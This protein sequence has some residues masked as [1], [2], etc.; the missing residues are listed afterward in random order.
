MASGGASHTTILPLGAIIQEFRVLVSDEADARSVSV[1]NRD[2]HESSKVIAGPESPSPGKQKREQNLVLNFP[3]ADLYQQYNVPYFGETIGRV[4]NRISGAKLN[5][6]NGREYELPENDKPRK[7]C[8]HG[9]TRGWGKKTW[10]GP[11]LV[12]RE[13]WDV[14]EYQLVSEDG[15]EGFPGTVRAKI[16]YSQK[17]EDGA[18]GE[19]VSVLD[20]EYE[21]ELVGDEVAETVVAL[22]NHR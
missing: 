15:D 22:T 1:I 21:A 4:A 12:T 7:V 17:Y 5:K 6:L 13:G 20:I 16:V 19:T 9:G 8:L 11:E 10:Q 18:N 14:K 2:Q 3:T